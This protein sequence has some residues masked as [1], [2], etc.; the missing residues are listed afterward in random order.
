MAQTVLA[1]MAV[2]IAAN[3]ASFN[4]GIQQSQ[5]SIKKFEGQIK[6]L[7]NQ[8]LAGFGILEVGRQLIEVTSQFQKFEA[9]LTNTLGNN[10]DAQY[11]L[12]SI[13]DFA[14]RTPF[15]VSEL[16]AAYVRWANQGLNPTIDKLTMLGDVASSLGAGLEQTA[17]AFKDL[18]VGQTK[19]IEEIGISATQA[20]GKIQLSFKGVNLEIEKNAEGVNKALEVYSK[21][22]G[23]LGTTE[24]VA[25]T[26]G[27]R[28]SNLKDSWDNFL[29]TIGQSSGG[30]IGSFVVS[31][32]SL[33]NTLSNLGS[34][35]DILSQKLF[36]WR[37]VNDLS[38]ETLDYAIKLGRTNAGNS[39]ADVIKSIEGNKTAVEQYNAV[40]SG[41][42]EVQRKFREEFEKQGETAE[43]NNR[44]WYAYFRDLT[45][46]ADMEKKQAEAAQK[47]ADNIKKT[48]EEAAKKADDDAK[49]AKEEED[50]KDRLRQ[51]IELEAKAWKNLM[52]IRSM[53][54]EDLKR[55][56]KELEKIQIAP[57]VPQ[58]VEV[59]AGVKNIAT[60]FAPQIAEYTKQIN[61]ANNANAL[62][63]DGINMIN[64]SFTQA[65]TQG[66]SDFING[67]SDV[68]T[69]QI[70]FGDNFLKA[71]SAFMKQFGQALIAL[72]IGKIQ[73]DNLFKSGPAGAIAAI[74]AGAALTFAAGAISRSFAQKSQ[75]LGGSIRSGSFSAQTITA[76]GQTQNIQITG[77]LVGSG[78]DLVAVINNTSFDNTQ[79]KGG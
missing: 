21:L 15:E 27:G 18:A 62:F 20:N 52:D 54:F 44:L 61:D 43:A 68:A 35:F 41:S 74:A 75:N 30:I 7:R 6:S 60:S 13:R 36:F 50:R 79:R 39:I 1:K 67:L 26:L 49:R 56:Y 8:L 51:K 66:I 34:T 32:T 57:I 42:M 58:T 25:N 47:S 76:T 72:G 78:R 12:Q 37:D 77:K 3:T 73:L 40:T 71:I 24:S 23:V 9:V 11:A 69:G 53:S 70:S 55:Q 46:R 63:T 5:Q 29:L 38:K 48:A 33:L 45:K 28:I 2:E 59:G 16:T 22:P 65:A 10:S 19:R 64:E 4:K 31:L 17:E 14:V